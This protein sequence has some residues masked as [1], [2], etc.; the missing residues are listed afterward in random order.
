MLA[1]KTY[2]YIYIFITVPGHVST[3]HSLYF[4]S[5]GFWWAHNLW[6]F[7]KTQSKHKVTV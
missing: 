4:V 1:E 6:E 3:K 2:I 7:R 5:N